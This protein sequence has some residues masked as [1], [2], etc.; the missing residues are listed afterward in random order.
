MIGRTL[1][2]RIP[3]F[4]AFELL[5]ASRE[6][7]NSLDPRDRARATEL[8]RSSKGDPRRLTSGER[9]EARELLRRLEVVRFARHVGP[10]ALKGRRS[11]RGRRR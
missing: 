8:L 5:M 10:I 11:R 1:T 6:H 7:W 9:D 4:L 2:R 3:L